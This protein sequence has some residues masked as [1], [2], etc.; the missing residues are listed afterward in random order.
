MLYIFHYIFIYIIFLIFWFFLYPHTLYF[1]FSTYFSYTINFLKKHIHCEYSISTWGESELKLD[2]FMA[3]RLEC[4]RGQLRQKA[5][6]NDS[7]FWGILQNFLTLLWPMYCTSHRYSDGKWSILC[8]KSTSTQGKVSVACLPACHFRELLK[9]FLQS[10]HTS[11]LCQ[12][13]LK[14]IVQ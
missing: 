1:F 3:P 4:K 7:H 11:M 8:P 10:C 14:I 6:Q 12:V 13:T 9:I 5:I 2:C